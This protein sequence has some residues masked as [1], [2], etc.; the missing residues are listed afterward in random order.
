MRTE[1]LA[2]VDTNVIVYAYD[3]D[4][5]AKRVRALEV[6]GDA[7]EFGELVC[8]TQVLGELFN[9]VT[10]K[11]NPPMTVAQAR[12][13]VQAYLP[14]ARVS[15]DNALVMRAI[16]LCSEKSV[17]FWDALIV[18]AAARA[19]AATLLTEDLNDGEEMLGVQILDPFTGL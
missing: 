13:E 2:F 14:L 15:T 9:V 5:P 16:D 11:R 6:L 12:A 8:S 19:G 18:A 7:S 17:S 10:R 3:A 4:A 1:G